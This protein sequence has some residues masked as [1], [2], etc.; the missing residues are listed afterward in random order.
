MKHWAHTVLEDAIWESNSIPAHVQKG[1]ARIIE[2]IETSEFHAFRTSELETLSVELSEC[3]DLNTLSEIMWAV[4]TSTG[5]QNFTIFVL[6]QGSAG[7]FKSRVCT[8]FNEG[9]IYQ[10]E[11]NAYQYVDPVICQA[12]KSNGAFQYSEL[13]NSS[14]V[15]E[16]F[17]QD[18]ERF[19]I[20]RNGLCFAFTLSDNTRIGVSLT[21]QDSAE[22]VKEKTRLDGYDIQ[23]L[24][25]LAA[26]KFRQISFGSALSDNMLSLE[27]LRFLYVLSSSSTPNDALKISAG[28][29]SN[30]SL[31]ASIRKKLKVDSVY[32]AIAI[33]A[34]KGWFD[35]LPYVQDEVLKPF[36][37]LEDIKLP[38]PDDE[39]EQQEMELPAE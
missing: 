17:W 34:A 28:Y 8:S 19:R 29:G 5:F 38:H 37:A 33:A 21:T 3:E 32:Q 20:G 15:V 39:S 16:D 2:L 12:M 36:R 23:Y 10:Y 35:Q 7:T 26:Q 24:A 11:K 25:N 22:Q 1:I 6:N 4:A 13:E 14:A 18:A 9:W 31:Q 30:S 27:E